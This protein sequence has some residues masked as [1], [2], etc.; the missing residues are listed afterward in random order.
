MNKTK[1]LRL[2]AWAAIGYI[3][4]ILP[5]CSLAQTLINV[6]LGGGTATTKVG[7]AGTGLSASD[8]WNFYTRDD[9][10]GGWLTLG[11]LSNLKRSD[12]STTT[13][14]LVVA[15]APGYWGNGSSDPMFAGYIYPF[16]GNATLDV[17]NL[18]AGSYDF[19]LYGQDGNYQV[20]V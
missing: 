9:G 4:A 19:Y 5:F 3:G 1:N 12:G 7:T 16:G 20:A 10:Q 14:G 11:A 13:A 8:F 6:D 2:R 17:T 18:S 15:N